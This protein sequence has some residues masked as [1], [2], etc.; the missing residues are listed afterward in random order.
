MSTIITINN[1]TGS[2][3]FN[4]YLCNSTNVTCIYIDTIPALSLPYD[5]Q[6]PSIM[7]NQ[8]SYN[9]KVVDNNGCIS[10]SNILI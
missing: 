10:I 2:S 8:P 4:I 7:E 1:I 9:L 3:P 5:F 6:V